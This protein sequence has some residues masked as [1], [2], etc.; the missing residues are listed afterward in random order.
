MK[1]SSFDWFK[2]DNAAKIFPGQNSRTWSNVFR[3]GVQLK[4]EIDPE[5]LLLAL[6]ATLK[7]MPSFNVRI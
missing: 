3:I 5:V 1:N 4:K 2:L 6:K 7:R